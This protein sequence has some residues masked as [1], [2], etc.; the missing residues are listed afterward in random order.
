MRRPDERGAV[1]VTAMLILLVLGAIAVV[2]VRSTVEEIASAGN[3]KMARQG[4]AVAETGSMLTMTAASGNAVD[5]MKTAN[6]C[7]VWANQLGQNAFDSKAWGSFGLDQW[8]VAGGKGP[9][10]VTKMVPEAGDTPAPGSSGERYCMR[11]FSWYT[12]G[13]V[14]GSLGETDAMTERRMGRKRILARV[15][16][17]P[18]DCSEGGITWSAAQCLATQAEP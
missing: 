6:Q 8:V 11:V 14:G 15:M 16:V 9:D 2:A 12:S 18:V 5:F 7:E 3:Y 1:L 17:G 10:F 13:W 4:L